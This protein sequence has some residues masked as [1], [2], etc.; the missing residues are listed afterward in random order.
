MTAENKRRKMDEGTLNIKE[1]VEREVFLKR[2]FPIKA[3]YVYDL[4]KNK[5]WAFVIENPLTGRIGLMEPEEFEDFL[6]IFLIM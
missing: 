5:I 3:N 6:N 1:R 4:E 2:F